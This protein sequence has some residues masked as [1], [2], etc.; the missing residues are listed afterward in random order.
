M[1]DHIKLYLCNHGLEEIDIANPLK[2][3]LAYLIVGILYQT[4]LL[5]IHTCLRRNHQYIEIKY[6]WN[7][8]VLG[9][10]MTIGLWPII[11]LRRM[12][13]YESMEQTLLHI[14]QTLD[15]NY[16]VKDLE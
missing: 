10:I 2:T 14:E 8:M 12:I 9:L 7:E 4:I 11:F 1:Y 5:T 13:R 16:E 6:T 15:E 3:V